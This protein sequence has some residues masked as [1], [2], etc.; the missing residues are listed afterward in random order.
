MENLKGQIVRSL[1]GR[2]AGSLYW[3]ASAEGDVL[4]LADGK[5]KRL[6]RLK[7]K[8]RKHVELTGQTIEAAG[9]GALRRALA[10]YRDEGGNYACQKTI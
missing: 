8:R 6:S 7:R 1:A 5:R 9:D 2:D 4:H 10:A 3:V